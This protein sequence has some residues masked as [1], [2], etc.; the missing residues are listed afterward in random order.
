M[1]SIVVYE[2]NVFKN[3]VA[4]FR[5]PMEELFEKHK[6]YVFGYGSL[7]YSEGW[8]DRGM[9]KPPRKEDLK[10]CTLNEF[11]RG[12]WGLWGEVNFY[13]VIPTPETK[14][15]GVVTEIKTLSD[16]VYLMSTEMIAGLHDYANYRVVDVT[17][18]ITGWKNKPNNVRVH[19]VVNRPVNRELVCNSNCSYDYYNKVWEGV[20]KER[21]K[22]FAK[23]FLKT[24][25]FINDDAAIDFIEQRRI[26]EWNQI[27]G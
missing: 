14:L 8:S 11:E 13:G 6:I 16:W 24:G 7:L 20:Q 2:P 15:N 18:N 25:G 3:E 10:E 1:E 9:R 27:K 17:D 21:T 12:P 26:K 4:V 5:Q 19:C 23:K 22:S